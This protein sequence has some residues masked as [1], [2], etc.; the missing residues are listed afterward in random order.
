MT[1]PD[2]IEQL[3]RDNYKA[4]LTF[5]NCLLH[6][7]EVARDIVHDVFASLMSEEVK[8]VTPS[9]L[10]SAVRFRCL[11]HIRNTSTH[12]RLNKMYALDLH[13][14]EG[15]DWPDD[16][17]MAKL[18]KV[19]E[20]FLP[21]Q[22]RRVVHLRFESGMTYKDIAEEISISQVAVYKHLRH[23]MNILRQNFNQH[24]R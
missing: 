21:E 18:R 3:F 19:I 16:E 5:A 24:E 23:A 10:I 22:T 2:D 12:E 13:E 11:K 8:Y 4:M 7:S 20:R 9:Y 6:D 1:T 17:D 15:E 14:I